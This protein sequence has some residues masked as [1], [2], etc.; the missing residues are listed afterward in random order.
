M[1]VH[2]LQRMGMKHIARTNNNPTEVLTGEVKATAEGLLQASAVGSCVAV[3]MYDARVRVGGLA[4][5]M[6]PGASPHGREAQNTR[7]AEDG[8]RE[9]VRAVTSLGAQPE[10]LVACMAGGGNVLKRDDDT[11]CEANVEAVARSLEEREIKLNASEVGGTERRSLSLD[12]DSGRILYTVGDSGP[13][14]LWEL[15][16][17]EQAGNDD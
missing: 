11:L 16:G 14:L 5:V 2:D 9:L 1:E 4:H 17:G 3:V 7:Y 12:V 10:R 13:K 15:G 8:I 6:L